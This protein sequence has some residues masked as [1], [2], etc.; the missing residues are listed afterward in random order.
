VQRLRLQEQAA[1][2]AVLESA[3]ARREA[4][5]AAGVGERAPGAAPSAPTPIEQIIG[6]TWAELLGRAQVDAHSNF[7]SLGGHSLLAIQ[8]LSRLREKLP[9]TLSLSDFF[10]NATV[11]QQAALV[12]GRLWPG[13][14]TGGKVW[15][16]GGAE[17]G[18]AADRSV[19][20]WEQALLQQLAP[21]AGPQTIP[22]R[23]RGLPCPLSPAQERVWFFEQLV[24]E[25][26]L[27]NE[28]EAVRLEGGLEVEAM[29]R[30]LNVIITRHEIL[31]TTI[32][33]INGEPVAVAH[34]SWPLRFKRIDL[35]GLAPAER[36]GEVER[37]L[38]EE[39]RRPYHLQAEPG[40]RGTVIELAGGE[41]VFILMMHHL[42]C[43]WSSEGVLWR[44]LSA[45]YQ[46]FRRGEAPTLPPLPIQHG[47]YAAWQK[48]QAA[49]GGFAED[50]GYWEEKLR[51][52]P[53]LL[54]LPTD[55]PRPAAM[56]Y[57]GARKRYRIGSALARALRDCGRR[58]QTSLF[59]LC[60][61]ALN[62]L[63]YRYTGSED[64]L[65]G[66]PLADRDRPEVESVIGFLLHTHALRTQL[67]GELTFRELLARVQKGVLDLYSHRAPPFDQVVSRV[68]P[69]RDL[70]YSPLFQVMINWR[71][72]DQQLSFIGMAGLKVESLLAES[73]TSKFDLT[74]MLTD[75][76]EE[77]WL[78]VEYSTD[79]F[80]EGRIERMVGHYQT[81]LAAAAAEPGRRLGELPLLGGAERQQLLVGW[82]QTQ[83]DYPRN[84]CVHE[85][86]EEQVERAPEATA[87]VFEDQRLTYRELNE[88]ANRLARRLQKLGVG[89]DT[90][91][92]VCME[93]SLEMVAGL[94]GILKAGGA[95]VPLDPEY[96]KERLAFMLED[97]RPLAV[98]TQ[99]KL[100]QVLPSH[101]ARV[102]YLDASDETDGE[103]E[104]RFGAESK[105]R[106]NCLAYVLYTSGST[107]RPK[108]VAIEHGSA[109]AFATWARRVFTDEEFGGVLFSTS[110]CFDLSVFELFV[111]LGN[112]GKVILA[113]NVLELPT[114]RA[115]QEVR[116][117]N[118]VPSAIAE[119]ARTHGIP[120]SVLT[121]NL[122]G[123]PLA[124]SLVDHLY[125][126]CLVQR[127]YDLYGPT[128]ATT[129]S[130]FTLRERG[131]RATIGRPIANTLIYILDGDRQ[132]VPIGVAGELH[133][134]GDGLAR[135]YL[136]RE[137]LTGEKFIPDP[138]N[139]R[140]GARLYKT[141]DL[142]R[143]LPDGN[144][145]YLGRLDHQVKI[146]GFRIELGEI[147]TVLNEHAAVKT[148][149]VLASE[150]NAGD[151]RLIAYV[152]PNQDG[153]AID[154]PEANVERISLWQAI[155]DNTY[156]SPG[157]PEDPSFNIAGW[158]SSYDG[159]PIPEEE[160]REWVDNTV[161]R[162]LALEPKRVLELG[163]G[164]GLLLLRLAPYCE[165][166]CGLDFSA[167][168]LG[169]IRQELRRQKQRLEAVT[170]LQRRAD[171]LEDLETGSFDAVILNSVVQYFPNIDYLVR[172][173][174]RA[175]R[176]VKPGGFIF[177]GDVRNL[178][179]LKAF[180][181]SVQLYQAPVE[182]PIG[183]LQQR[184]SKQMSQEEELLIAPEFFLAVKRH[185]AGVSD[186]E[187][188]LKR[189]RHHNEMTL[190]RYDVLLHIGSCPGANGSL[191]PWD[192]RQKKLTL[193]ALRD[194]LEQTQPPLL[195]VRGIP[196]ARLQRELKLLEWLE[197]KDQTVSVS[198][199]REAV[200]EAALDPGIEPEDLWKLGEMLP[201]SVEVTWSDPSRL[202]AC[203]ALFR[204]R[205]NGQISDMQALWAGRATGAAK[206]WSW[207]ANS[208][209]QGSYARK[210]IPSLR[211]FLKGRMPEYMVPSAFLVL[212]KL[213][214]TPNGKVDRKALPAPHTFG[215]SAGGLGLLPR[216]ETE[217]AIAEMWREVLHLER[218]GI[219][220]SFFDLG[221]HSLL[222]VQIQSRL[223]TVFGVELGLRSLYDAPTVAGM[224]ETISKRRVEQDMSEEALLRQEIG[225]LNDEEVEA[226][227]GSRGEGD[228]AQT[229]KGA[230]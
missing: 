12:R 154:N 35:S 209:L 31:R 189:G 83:R 156:N 109:V 169:S 149:A 20:G 203:D 99:R 191:E 53:D 135:G 181:F 110:I 192:W 134:G 26:P 123:E 104:R 197:G 84:K 45:L 199:C 93:R 183:E 175:S 57:R 179:L 37:L 69:K 122:A 155:W 153:E 27:Y 55:R 72:R 206:P 162:V 204:R 163:C 124:Q 180:C 91:V 161:K 165:R 8:C 187:I 62:A 150:D 63:L 158:R 147:E 132:P 51:G 81:L 138:F 167:R 34:E 141:G 28:S 128:E 185:L 78:E 186:V 15:P 151:K 145:E 30:A 111:T 75:G 130:T 125:E 137:E 32:E 36:Q 87:V 47:D 116:M 217:R 102:V 67:G 172:V 133:I 108:G 73:R 92:G 54:E 213:P 129:Y 142:A 43:D 200:E 174:E 146:R 227:L 107:G 74:W 214:L 101:Q 89:P 198:K 61:A 5:A 176:T 17:G 41:H 11:A 14:A 222:L 103:I 211:D 201:Y 168:A 2:P 95:Y 42:I 160:M 182:S 9:I 114:L 113:K 59:T 226:E 100:Q 139:R 86:F 85:L 157:P 33:V 117:I 171:D 152:V 66:I 79:L 164:T 216:N 215:Q 7:F 50:L 94:L 230:P 46:A 219:E 208:P 90:L 56:S 202:G 3:S 115:A 39:P 71:D 106:A 18:A 76:G 190:F 68:Q 148:A 112:G 159:Q 1:Q 205:D 22:R 97:A 188:Q 220:D 48:G 58:E 140:P 4:C 16:G 25:V 77:I 225:G 19:A 195:H 229:T 224:A 88:R 98:V 120:R 13:T 210:L 228:S 60:T 82:N 6:E 121:V 136:H 212:E 21:S 38:V 173:L 80:E 119:L 52:A 184:I 96:P 221:G 64:I 24:P 127:V 23:D 29:E 144:I 126:R 166:Y 40:I 131:G 178:H 196:N 49:E 65:L 118:T 10:E 177:L 143:Y 70:S 170:L 218:V 105:G 207:Y 194:H 223:S 193:P 44:E